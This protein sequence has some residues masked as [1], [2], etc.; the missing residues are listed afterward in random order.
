MHNWSR[1][2]L[3]LNVANPGSIQYHIVP[4]YHCIQLWTPQYTSEMVQIISAIFGHM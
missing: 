1:E 2:I 3:A 4:K